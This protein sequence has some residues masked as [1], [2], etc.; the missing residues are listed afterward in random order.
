MTSSRF[1]SF[2]SAYLSWV[3]RGN[4]GM[5]KASGGSCMD[6]LFRLFCSFLDVAYTP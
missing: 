1:L 4:A 3:R 6:S 2:I 5:Y